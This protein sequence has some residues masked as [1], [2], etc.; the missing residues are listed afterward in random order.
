M[1]TV[2]NLIEQATA[3]GATLTPNGDRLKVKMPRPL[4]GD[5]LEAL[6]A[7]KAAILAELTRSPLPT[8]EEVKDWTLADVDRRR[9][10]I[11][12]RSRLL[13]CGLWIVPAGDPGPGDRLPVYTTDE[14]RELLKLSPADLADSVQRVHLAKMAMG[15][16][17]TVEEVIRP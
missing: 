8:P 3:A 4:S 10:R 16:A 13:N 7:H 2:R 1:S 9:I 12:I 5:L 17:A 14:V 11:K 15:P 6:R